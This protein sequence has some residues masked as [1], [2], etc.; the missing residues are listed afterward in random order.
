MGLYTR[1]DPRLV[2]TAMI[3][4]TAMQVPSPDEALISSENRWSESFRS[5]V[6]RKVSQGSAPAPRP[7]DWESDWLRPEMENDTDE[8]CEWRPVKADDEATDPG[9]CVKG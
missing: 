3:L 9:P 5:G 6:H 7:C 4:D 8:L 2:P 1:I